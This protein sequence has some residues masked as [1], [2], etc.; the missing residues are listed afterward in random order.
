MR[1]CLKIVP[2]VFTVA[3]IHPPVPSQ[4]SVGPYPPA[5]PQTLHGA[6][7]PHLSYGGQ[8]TLIG[9][10]VF[11]YLERPSP[12]VTIGDSSLRGFDALDRLRHLQ[13]RGRRSR[14]GGAC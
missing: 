3:L 2:F 5:I 13:E 4:P 14:V 7:D 6:A 8:C 9:I 10:R 12:S 11:T 1:L